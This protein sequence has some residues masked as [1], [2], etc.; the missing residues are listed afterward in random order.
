MLVV[1]YLTQD[2]MLYEHPTRA[3]EWDQLAG[4]PRR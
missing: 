3:T 2:L 1:D 4:H